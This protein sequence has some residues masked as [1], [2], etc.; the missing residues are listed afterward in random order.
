MKSAICRIVPLLFVSLVL[1]ITGCAS[2][3]KDDENVLVVAST[4]AFKR[5]NGEFENTAYFLKH[6]PARIAVL[7]FAKG[8]EKS[9]SIDY[10]SENPPEIVRKGL[11]NHIASLPFKDLELHQTDERL[12]NAALT[13]PAALDALIADNPEKLKSLLGVDAVFTGQVTHFDRIYVGIYSQIAVGCEVKFWDLKS[14]RLLWRAKHVQRAHAGGISTSP[15]GLVISA[16]ASIWNLKQDEMLSQTDDLFREIVS[17]IDL[18][19]SARIALAAAPRIDMFAAVNA[20]K[21]FTLG[22]KAV[23][24]V[25][26]DP[27][28]QVVVDLG[29][30]KS[31]ISLAPVSAQ[32]KTQIRSEVL[33]AIEAAAAA[34]G[35]QLTPEMLS[36]IASEL[37]SREIY[38]G[39]YQVAPDEQAY[40]LTPR[41]Y[42]VNP[43]GMQAQAVDAVHLVDIDSL[44]PGPVGAVSAESLDGKVRFTWAPSEAEDLN[45]YEVWTSAAPISGFTMA[46]TSEAP[47]ATIADRRN[48]D[49]FYARVRPVDKAG[50]VGSFSKAAMAVALPVAGLLALPQPGPSVGGDIAAPVFLSAE[51]SPFTVTA[52]LR[53]VSGGAVHIAPGVSLMFNAGAGIVVEGG[54]LFAYGDTDRPIRMAPKSETA[55]PGAWRG[56]VLNDAASSGLYHTVI[57]KA[58]TGVAIMGGTPALQHVTISQCDQAGL[59]LK[60]NA[61]P[62]VSCVTFNENHG[63]G[64]VVLEGVGLKPVF[65]NNTFINNEFQVQ[66]YAPIQVD[67]SGNYWGTPDPDMAGFMGDVITQ[68]VLTAVPDACAAP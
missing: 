40:G 31:G 2:V 34:A 55:G 1:V 52:P 29:D 42:V 65:R 3:V 37:G 68:P 20:E 56:V 9:Y 57:E 25:V 26:G 11:Y 49:T 61:A 33:S 46:L 15:V 36:G 24:R 16:M 50:N 13:D 44:P 54:R 12:K 43:D 38:E 45:G 23:F 48:F 14:G 53:V 22:K 18:P 30:F 17:T 63:M 62:E 47:E 41:V 51:K 6:K 67:M 60:D 32:R 58:E 35:Q 64:A 66:N 21:P 39:A 10:A 4:E 19:A 8:E 59:Q 5:F 27:G 28:C 7:P